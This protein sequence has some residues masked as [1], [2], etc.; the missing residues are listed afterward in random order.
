MGRSLSIIHLCI[1]KLFSSTHWV[2]LQP[3]SFSSHRIHKEHMNIPFKFRKCFPKRYLISASRKHYWTESISI[4]TLPARELGVR[5]ACVSPAPVSAER[6]GNSDLSLA[7][8]AN[9]PVLPPT[10][11]SLWP[12]QA[13]QASQPSQPCINSLMTLEKY[14]NC[15]STTSH[16]V[17]KEIGESWNWQHI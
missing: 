16:S 1:S 12:G 17:P 4:S 9:D 15:F 3:P 13:L 14:G 10:S 6:S 8:A 5:K 7:G 11:A 2:E